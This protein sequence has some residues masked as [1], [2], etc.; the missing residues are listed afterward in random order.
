[1]MKQDH[2]ERV[3]HTLQYVFPIIQG[4]TMMPKNSS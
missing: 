4:K 2:E 1:M 3:Q